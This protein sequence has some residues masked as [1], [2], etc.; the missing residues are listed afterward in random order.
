MNIAVIGTG[1]MGRALLSALVKQ[2]DLNLCAFDKIPSALKLLPQRVAVRA[3]TEWKSAN[4]VPDVV[5]IAVKP[6]D[7]GPTLTELRGA[8]GN[9]TKKVVW[10]SIAAGISLS[11]IAEYIG[12]DMRICRAMPNTPALIGL[13]M[14]AF[15]VNEFCSDADCEMA[16]RILGSCGKVVQVPEKLLN[17]V[18]GLSGSGPA[19]V[20]SF[21]EALIEGGVTAGLPTE[22]ASTLAI[23]TVIGAA[24]MVEST[25]ESP[26]TL[27]GRVMSP[28]GTTARGLLALEQ[29]NFKFTVMKAVLDATAR[30][31]EL[32]SNRNIKEQK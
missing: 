25:G 11:A 18:T 4:Y 10:I 23:Q 32:G 31:D 13:G 28:G 9:D 21:I 14:T 17:A 20:Y 7:I 22:T 27:K 26:A 8:L 30:A 3:P 19:F 15:S 5:I 1:N 12:T 6:Q 2:E 24:R 16:Q 29:N